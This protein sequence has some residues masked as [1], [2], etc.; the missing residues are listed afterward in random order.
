MSASVCVAVAA[1]YL[2]MDFAPDRS[3][4]NICAFNTI[5]MYSHTRY[6]HKWGRLIVYSMLT[7]IKVAEVAR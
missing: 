6:L 4:E 1:L 2:L 3:F 5:N 7:T